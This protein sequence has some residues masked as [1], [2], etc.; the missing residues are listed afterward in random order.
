[1]KAPGTENLYP[2]EVDLPYL[3]DLERARRTLVEMCAQATVTVQ[4][5]QAR[6]NDVT[7]HL[8]GGNYPQD[9][10]SSILAEVRT[11]DDEFD[12]LSADLAVLSA[13]VGAYS[14]WL[15]IAS[16]RRAVIEKSAQLGREGI[17]IGAR[18]ERLDNE[19][20]AHLS[21]DWQQGLTQGDTYERR[22]KALNEAI[23]ERENQANRKFQ[24]LQDAFFAQLH[25]AQCPKE[26]LWSPIIF[27]Q[28]D[29]ERVYDQ[30]YT[31]AGRAAIATVDHAED[32][33]QRLCSELRQKLASPNRERIVDQANKL[34]DELTGLTAK[35]PYSMANEP[36]MIREFDGQS[37]AVFYQFIAEVKMVW[38]KIPLYQEQINKLI[39]PNKRLT[40]SPLE[41]AIMDQIRGDELVD[42]AAIWEFL[43]PNN[44]DQV[45]LSVRGLWE[46]ELIR[47]RF[48]KTSER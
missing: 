18:L 19:I 17:E 36:Q 48:G 7:Q 9:T 33:I 5:R 1:L 14:T 43:D 30:L 6:I 21:A 41:N 26:K 20:A 23:D 28:T 3:D 35:L 12:Q 25:S 2:L 22:F 34:L 8:I 11:F 44:P 15:R 39:I 40:P 32:A 13:T 29:V 31:Y 38:T 42:L 10:L 47:I 37:S 46:K 4:D 24:R 16:A 45:W 27:S